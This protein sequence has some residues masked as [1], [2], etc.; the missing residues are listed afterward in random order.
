VAAF[1]LAAMPCSNKV[2]LDQVQDRG[3][4]NVGE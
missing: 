2:S 4:K 3:Q 1:W